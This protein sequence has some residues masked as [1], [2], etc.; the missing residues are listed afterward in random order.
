[1]DRTRNSCK[2]II[3]KRQPKIRI[4]KCGAIGS[5]SQYTSRCD[6][7]KLPKQTSLLLDELQT[8]T[9]P[10]SGWWNQQLVGTFADNLEYNVRRTE[11]NQLMRISEMRPGPKM[12]EK[13]VPTNEI[14]DSFA[15]LKRHHWFANIFRSLMNLGVYFRL[16]CQ[17]WYAWTQCGAHSTGSKW[18]GYEYRLA[19]E[20]V[21]DG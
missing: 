13:L 14:R 9:I 3:Q 17:I 1:M 8:R 7:E 15:V 2:W 21:C 12:G 10:V 19:Y 4:F 5:K 6:S 11:L 18:Y 16:L 20:F